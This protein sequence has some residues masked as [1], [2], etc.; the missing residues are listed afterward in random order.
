MRV[1]SYRA[2]RIE[3]LCKTDA[4][5]TA[6]EDVRDLCQHEGV[7][8]DDGTY[9]PRAVIDDDGICL[10]PPP[11]SDQGKLRKLFRQRHGPEV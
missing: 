6:P 1:R 8:C 7:C 11:S 10:S 4:P 2:H 5:T 3:D 9:P